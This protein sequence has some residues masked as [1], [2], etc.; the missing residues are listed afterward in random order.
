MVKKLNIFI[1]LIAVTLV[2]SGQES[3]TLDLCRARV[4]EY[5]PTLKQQEKMVESTEANIKAQKKDY[6]PTIDVNGDYTFLQNPIT[7]ET[8]G[9][10]S[11]SLQNLYGFGAPIIQNV[12]RGSSVRRAN[13]MAGLQKAYASDSR[14]N[15]EDLLL[16]E[17]E[18]AFWNAVYNEELLQLIVDYEKVIDELAAVIQDK[19]EAEIISRNDLLLV[20]VRQNE[21]ELYRLVTTNQFDV[22]LMELNRIIGYPL[23]QKLPLQGNLDEVLV[24]SLDFS[25]DSVLIN[26]PDLAAQNKAVEMQKT[27]AE[28]V[29]SQYL[30]SLYVGIVPSWGAP[31]TN[32]G[33][34]DPNYNTSFMAGM[35]IPITRW[36]KKKQDV[37]KELLKAEAA[38]FELKELQ[39]EVKLNINSSGYQLAESI[40]R[41]ELT[42]NSLQKAQENLNIM[43]DRY[44]E[45]L[46]S[47]LEVLDAQEFW[48]R[49]YKDMLDAQV[50]Y[51]RAYA[52]YKQS[53]G[54]I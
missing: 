46:S 21:A 27:N 24:H 49:S 4:I 47:I 52:Y 1:F 13:E 44:L 6:L 18:L 40:R 5:N 19:V 45:G 23:V 11:E 35:N 36:G 2:A 41:I 9:V 37:G 22:S 30:P 14:D 38:T 8:D 34:T 10:S 16:L 54:Q 39:D 25:L 26:R 15:V 48:Q 42:K 3:L 7:V 29:K 17:T 51:K 20:E 50:Y 28:L 53:I 32:I 33:A 31:N 12:Y 43:T